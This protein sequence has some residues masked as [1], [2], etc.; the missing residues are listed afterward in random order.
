MVTPAALVEAVRKIQD[1]N[2][3]CPPIVSQEAAVAAMDEGRSYCAP[4]LTQL[5]GVRKFVLESLASVGDRVSFP[6]PQGAFYALIRLAT[7]LSDL[8]VTRTLI[9][10]YGVAVIPGSAFGL[11]DGCYLRIAYGALERETVMEAMGRLISGISE[12]AGE[13][14]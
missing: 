12:I 7:P 1:T 2:L 6:V 3:I 10:R 4:F 13:G 11:E 9:E 5:A 8:E 14:I